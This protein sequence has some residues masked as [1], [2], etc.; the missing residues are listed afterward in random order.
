M[1]S[2]QDIRPTQSGIKK[3]QPKRRNSSGL[4]AAAGVMISLI[5]VTAVAWLFLQPGA[6]VDLNNVSVIQQKIGR[7]YSLPVNEE[8]AMFTVTDKEQIT[9][10]FLKI[11]QNGDKVLVYQEAKRIIVYR[12]SI[13]KIIDVGPVVI[14][15]DG[16]STQ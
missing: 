2:I 3:S 14:A 15:A 7:H 10:E 1:N 9:T 16:Q 11:A 13:D 5:I 12:P 4:L 8:P 6:T